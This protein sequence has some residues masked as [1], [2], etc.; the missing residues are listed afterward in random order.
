M[1]YATV[2]SRVSGLLLSALLILPLAVS[3]EEEEAEN[4]P[5]SDLTMT[6]PERHVSAT[7]ECVA[8]EAEMRRNHMK[9]ILHQ[10]DE[11]MHRGIRTRRHSLEECVNC[12]A[13]KNDQG[14]YIPVNAENQFCSSCHTYAA[15]NIDCFQCHATKPVRA[16]S[17]DG[18]S[19]SAPHP[20][21]GPGNEPHPFLVS[22]GNAQ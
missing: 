22:E 12:H 7:E 20:S 11:T 6:E 9:F 19:A 21:A 17:L 8:P 4:L 5:F 16:S 18:R 13:A 14:E 15:V 10:R 1:T 3:A 2:A